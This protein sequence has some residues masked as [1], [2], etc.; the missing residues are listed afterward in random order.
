MTQN[1]TLTR[2]VTPFDP[3][4]I[5][6]LMWN[7]TTFDPKC[8]NVLTWNVPTFDPKWNNIFNTKCNKQNVTAWK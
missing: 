7:V 2:N 1:V 5:N 4:C 6:V 3:K 8:N